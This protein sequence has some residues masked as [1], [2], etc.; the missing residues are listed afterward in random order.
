MIHPTALV[1]S[2]AIGENTNIWAF[3]H[4]MRGV[5]I[6][7]NCNV[8]DHCFIESGVEIGDNVT[9][10]N[11]N[12]LFVGVTV[13]NGVFIGP[14]AIF[15]NDLYPRSPRL[16]EVGEKYKTGEWLTPTRLGYGCSIGAG[17]VIVAGHDIGRF[18]SVGAGSIV[19]KDVKDYALVVGNPARQVGWVCQCG[20]RL[21][22]KELSTSCAACGKKY[23]LDVASNQLAYIAED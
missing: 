23:E 17:A 8:G 15:T 6:G 12:T 10:K 14:N 11:N 9:I 2:D 20:K 22:T 19:T 5:T 4:I 21:D 18:A 3:T 7:K 1:E 16:P 13:E